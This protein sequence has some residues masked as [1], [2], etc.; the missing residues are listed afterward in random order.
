M[1]PFVQLLTGVFLLSATFTYAWWSFL[2]PARLRI[3]LVGIGL[4]VDLQAKR[5]GIYGS[6]DHHASRRQV[7]LT[8]KAAELFTWWMVFSVAVHF[9]DELSQ[10]SASHA[11]K[12]SNASRK[13]SETSRAAEPALAH[14]T[15]Q[16]ISDC[17]YKHMLY[18]TAPGILL[19]T[20]AAILGYFEP[21]KHLVR[22]VVDFI[23]RPANGGPMLTPVMV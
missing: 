15:S 7:E 6:E 17:L 1:N 22:Q 12:K 9:Y 4:E 20:L 11:R 5:L 14:L 13:K 23:A 8:L 18:H 3:Q 10:P 21:M 19:V 16:K 2:G